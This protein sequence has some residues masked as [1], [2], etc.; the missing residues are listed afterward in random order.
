MPTMMG[1]PNPRTDARRASFSTLAP[2]YH[3]DLARPFE[4][5]L[6]RRQ[7]YAEQ[8]WKSACRDRLRAGAL[9]E[10]RRKAGGRRGIGTKHLLRKNCDWPIQLG[11]NSAESGT[12]CSTLV[13]LLPDALFERSRQVAAW[14]A[15]GKYGPSTSRT[16]KPRSDRP[17][18]PRHA[19]TSAESEPENQPHDL[20]PRVCGA[21]TPC[22]KE[23]YYKRRVARKR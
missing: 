2:V 14:P 12:V 19:F 23:A 4:E 20:P 22:L 15:V 5:R 18:F 9:G 13:T 10:L 1:G 21:L 17:A 7:L 8:V 11:K 6:V 3:V 16:S